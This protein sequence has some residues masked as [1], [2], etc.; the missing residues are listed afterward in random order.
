MSK[1]SGLVTAALV[2]PGK[3]AN[4]QT[5]VTMVASDTFELLPSRSLL[6]PLRPP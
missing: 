2:P 6:H 1:T 5:F 3:L 4:R